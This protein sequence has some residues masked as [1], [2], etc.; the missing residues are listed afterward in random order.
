MNPVR[1]PRRQRVRHC[2]ANTPITPTKASGHEPIGA[3]AKAV[4]TPD[5]AAIA[6]AASTPIRDRES[7]STTVRPDDVVTEDNPTVN[8]RCQALR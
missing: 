1:A 4:T 7:G 8:P 5:T 3:N 2:T 6:T